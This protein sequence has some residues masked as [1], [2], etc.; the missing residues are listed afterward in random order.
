MRA[1]EENGPVRGSAFGLGE[2]R[3]GSHLEGQFAKQQSIT[4]PNEPTLR[5][6]Q[7]FPFEARATLRKQCEPSSA[8][9]TMKRPIAGAS[10]TA[11]SLQ[12]A[13]RLVLS[14]PDLAELQSAPSERERNSNQWRE[15]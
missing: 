11:H 5:G 9:A 15:K 12:R 2:L 7:A 14:R 1:V 4:H 3:A 8:V 10:I 13:I 6:D